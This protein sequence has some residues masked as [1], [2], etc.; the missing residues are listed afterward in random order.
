[1]FH[2]HRISPGQRMA[3]PLISLRK[4]DGANLEPILSRRELLRIAGAGAAASATWASIP[5]AI[6]ANNVPEAIEELLAGRTGIE[7]ARIRLELPLRFDYGNTVPLGF[8][9]DGPT[10]EENHVRT[11]TVF[12]QGN[13]FPEVASFHFAPA[14]RTASAST[15]IRLNA[16][17]REVVA[18]AELTDG[19]VWLGRRTIE[20]AVS[21]C[22]VEA[23]M[24]SGDV[25]PRPEPRLTV[26]AARGGEI[27]EIKTM[28]SHRMESGLRVDTAGRPIPR[29]II[30]RMVCSRDGEAI[31]TAD[32]S[33][34]IA[35][36]AYL[37]FFVM[38]REP[39]LLTFAW[40]EDG[41]AVYQASRPLPVI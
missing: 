24:E 40:H 15:R 37:N 33:P 10:T 21:G 19:S 23:G 6:A 28:I 4:A 5:L 29:R 26:P 13:P 12:A 39:A 8:T 1:M 27:V 11:V 2:G 31:F 25:V 9:V 18:V 22:G 32:L 3:G 35:A 34:A 38:A 17:Q 30:N 14:S 20:V 7:S 16:G 36:N 41:G